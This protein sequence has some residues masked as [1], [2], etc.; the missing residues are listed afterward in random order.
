MRT[1][2]TQFSGPVTIT[3]T[4][5]DHAFLSPISAFIFPNSSLFECNQSAHFPCLFLRL[6]PFGWAQGR[7]RVAF[8]IPFVV[9]SSNHWNASLLAWST[10]TIT[11]F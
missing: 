5:H 7:L 1:I 2:C 8:S 4:N 11:I 9:S 6:E 10:N 3:S